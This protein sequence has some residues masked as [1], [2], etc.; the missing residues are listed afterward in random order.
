M[1]RKVVKSE[2]DGTDNWSGAIPQEVIGEKRGFSP[3]IIFASMAYRDF[4]YLWLG[5]ITHAGALWLEQIARP[6]LILQLTGSATQLG[7]VILTR[8]VPAVVFGLLAGPVADSFNRRTVI[9]IT[10]VVVL[11]LSAL[12][13]LIIVLGWIQVWHIYVFS[14]LRGATMAFDQPARRAMIPSI[15]PRYLVTNAMALSTGSMQVMR[16]VGAAGAGLL[17]GYY[18]I[19]APFV[20]I[21]FIYVGAVFFTWMLRTKDHDRRGYQGM[22]SMG[23]DLIEGLKFAWNSPMVRGVL[24]I[25]LGYFAFG[26]AFMQVFAPVFATQVLDIGEKGFGFMIAVMGLGGF[27]GALILAAA[28]PSKRRGAIMLVMLVVFGLMLILFSATTYLNSIILVFVV[29]LVLGMAQ[30]GF[31]PIINAV[32]VDAAPEHM[33]GRV[34]GILSLDRAMMALGAAIA[35]FLAT[36]L[37]AQHAQILFGLGCVITAGIIFAAYPAVRRID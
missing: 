34:L 3:R 32:L 7:L 29:I 6:L 5:Q 13:A 19:A 37:G 33:R 24:I 2:T 4:V 28:N 18:G 11:V 16:I 26:M 10:K 20:V 31:F 36:T 22:R 15:V 23:G 1:E 14:F 35:G 27:L 21:V 25:A 12:F 8:T 17:M 9:L 30:A